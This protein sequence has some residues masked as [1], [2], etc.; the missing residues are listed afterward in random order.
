[1][2]DDPLE[3]EY[4]NRVDWFSYFIV[5]TAKQTLK[6]AWAVGRI[7]TLDQ[8]KGSLRQD[9]RTLRQI[10]EQNGNDAL[11]SRLQRWALDVRSDITPQTSTLDVICGQTDIP[12]NF[13][14]IITVSEVDVPLAPMGLG[15]TYEKRAARLIR[16]DEFTSLAAP[17]N[18]VDEYAAK[19]DDLGYSFP[20]LPIEVV[21][22]HMSHF[23]IQELAHAQRVA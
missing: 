16:P 9:L 12:G 7:G 8:S 14:A 10:R 6:T 23:P 4:G 5:G 2:P 21:E 22:Y 13:G 15:G 11:Y 20:V 3:W 17:L 19:V 18:K 1:V